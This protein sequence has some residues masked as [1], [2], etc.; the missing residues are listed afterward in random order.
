MVA[1]GMAEGPRM[2]RRC[3][4][5]ALA[6]PLCACAF[7]QQ[8][9]GLD[10]GLPAEA[11]S[12]T[13]PHVPA[14]RADPAPKRPAATFP[15]ILQPGHWEWR[16]GDYQWMPAAWVARLTAGSPQWVGGF[17]TPSGGACVWHNGHFQW[18]GQAQ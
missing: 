10:L 9:S 13:C 11:A 4:P 14:R 18:P 7:Q 15:Q 8:G 5:A 2:I 6:L 3:L 1:G 17:W 16:D 12:V